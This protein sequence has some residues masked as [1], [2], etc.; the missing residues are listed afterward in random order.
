MNMIVIL[1]IGYLIGCISPAALLAKIK[2]VDL[3]QE[4]TKNLGA[5]NTALVLGR[6]SGLFVMLV[7]ILKSILSAK[8]SQMLF[9]Q[10]SCAGMV[11]CIGCILGH[12]FPVFL[13]FRG[14]KGLAAF[15]GMVLAYNPWFFVM[16]LIP[17]VVLMVILNTGVAVPM[18]ACVMF[19]I[20]VAMYGNGIAESIMALIA[21]GIIIIMHQENLKL[22]LK[23]RD[24]VSVRN[25]FGKMFL[26]K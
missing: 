25:F 4:S 21:S 7:D 14:G 19:P 8:L 2:N 13:H 12:C 20:L 9:P 11:A 22:A 15:G 24:V 16:I 26:K 17:G 3:K 18:L 10:I 5:T 6:G 1:L 23:R